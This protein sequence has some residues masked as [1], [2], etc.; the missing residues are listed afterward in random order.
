MYSKQVIGM[1]CKVLDS[2]NYVKSQVYKMDLAVDLAYV[3]MI[4]RLPMLMVG[5]PGTGKSH[6]SKIIAK[7]FG[8]RDIDWF[9]QSITAKTSP[10]KLF[11]GLIAEKMLQ[12]IEEYNLSVGAATKTGVI[13]DELY[14]SHHPAMMNSLLNFYDEEPTIYS[15]GVNQ[16]VGWQWA[17]NTTNFED[18]PEDLT[19]CPLWDRQGAKYIVDNMSHSDSRQ[20]LMMVMAQKQQSTKIPQ[21]AIEDL[22]LA[23][24]S[25]MSIELDK[26]TIDIF[27][28]TV[29]PVLEKYAYISQR[30]INSF[31]VGKQGHPSILQAIAYISQQSTVTPDLLG[32][33]AW[34]CWQDVSKVKEMVSTLES[35]RI[36]PAVKAYQSLSKDIEKYLSGVRSGK[37]SSYES[38]KEAGN[39]VREA[40]ASTLKALSNHDRAQVPQS[41]R[42]SLKELTDESIHVADKV[43]GTQVEEIEF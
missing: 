32:M 26:N 40:V 11:G 33:L 43:L 31:F 9:Y 29:L 2:M 21:L 4:A 27:Y 17:F 30:K 28:K 15:G 42:K 38:A 1:G 10:E 18:L 23:R 13:F 19:Y 37:Y 34:F 14:K 6:A 7:M 36:P 39:I 35:R 8:Q 5:N 16:Q 12:G 3:C 41:L 20:A 24:K 22:E 25:A